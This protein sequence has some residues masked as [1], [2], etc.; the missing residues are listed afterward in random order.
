MSGCHPG[1]SQGQWHKDKAATSHIPCYHHSFSLDETKS[2]L[3]WQFRK[4]KQEN[5]SVVAKHGRFLSKI[6]PLLALRRQDANN[7]LANLHF[8]RV[9][10]YLREQ[11][12]YCKISGKIVWWFNRVEDVYGQQKH[13][14]SQEL[15]QGQIPGPAEAHGVLMRLTLGIISTTL[16]GSVGRA[17]SGVCPT[18]CSPQLS[19]KRWL[20]KSLL[21]GMKSSARCSVNT[22]QPP[23]V[24][25]SGLFPR[26]FRAG[27]KH[28]CSDSPNSWSQPVVST[29]HVR[30]RKMLAWT[31][32]AGDCGVQRKWDPGNFKLG[33]YEKKL[34]QDIMTLMSFFWPDPLDNPSK[35]EWWVSFLLS[36]LTQSNS[37][38]HK[39][40]TQTWIQPNGACSSAWTTCMF[41]FI[42]LILEKNWKRMANFTRSGTKP[43]LSLSVD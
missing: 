36:M 38:D 37:V 40:E 6:F 19:M 25:K 22:T 4:L 3:V 5:L 1:A 33:S 7:K 43:Q 8:R 14:L 10:T 20:G 41:C 17:V 2:F 32:L 11:K 15:K 42:L 29:A 35:S 12:S 9:C 30:G 23:P 24:G 16:A 31:R 18:W 26:V 13:V 21:V 28:G 34:L 39:T 27:T